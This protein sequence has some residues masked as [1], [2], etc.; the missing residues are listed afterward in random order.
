MIHQAELLPALIAMQ[1]WGNNLKNKKV[2]LFVDNDAARHALVKGRSTNAASD[3]IL[4]TFW[5]I[6]AEH[7]IQI[8]VERVPSKSNPADGPSRD[9]WTWCNKHHCKLIH[10][11]IT[12][13]WH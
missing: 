8:W 9:D 12:M 13:N 6:V 11:R 7:E 5:E 4:I 3:E 1:T 10:P 2:I